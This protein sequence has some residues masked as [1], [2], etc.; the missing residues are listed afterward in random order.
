MG[1][2]LLLCSEK[3]KVKLQQNLDLNLPVG[4]V[5]ISLE[6]VEGEENWK[7]LIENVKKKLD[8]RSIR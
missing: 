7:N 2:T 6:I 5:K 3:D 1:A 4:W 8:S